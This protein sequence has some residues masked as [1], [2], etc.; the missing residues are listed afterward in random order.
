MNLQD[1]VGG[2]RGTIIY[3]PF[4]TASSRMFRSFVFSAEE[5]LLALLEDANPL[6]TLVACIDSR[7]G[8]AL[9]GP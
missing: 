2:R 9:K 8:D 5:W 4:P 3:V 6:Y 7:E 1:E